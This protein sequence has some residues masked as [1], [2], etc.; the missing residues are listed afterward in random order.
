MR[1]GASVIQLLAFSVEPRGEEIF[2]ALSRR[3]ICGSIQ[4]G[5]GR[6]KGR[7]SFSEEKEAK[8]LFLIWAWGFANA[9]LRSSKSFCAGGAPPLFSKSGYLMIDDGG[10]DF[11]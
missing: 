9:R 5:F 2:L 7:P 1:N 10:D 6:E 8:R 3:V 11:F 4:Y